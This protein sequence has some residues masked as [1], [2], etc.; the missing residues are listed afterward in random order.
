MEF[1]NAPIGP[2]NLATE[3]HPQTC[4]TSRLLDFTSKELNEILENNIYNGREDTHTGKDKELGMR[5]NEIEGKR[6]KVLTF[7]SKR[8]KHV[9]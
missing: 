2:N 9:F 5:K 1:I 3:F 8:Q 6:K 4:Y 7:N